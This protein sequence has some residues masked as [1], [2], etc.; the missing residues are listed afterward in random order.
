MEKVWRE[1]RR[2]LQKVYSKDD[3]NALQN[4]LDNQEEQSQ[5]DHK[6]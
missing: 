1:A 4:E 6:S 5:E 3:E 2:L